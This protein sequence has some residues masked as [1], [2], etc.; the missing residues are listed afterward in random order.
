MVNRMGVCV[1]LLWWVYCSKNPPAAFQ[2]FM[3]VGPSAGVDA[4][5][6]AMVLVSVVGVWG[7]GGGNDDQRCSCS[8]IFALLLWR[9]SPVVRFAPVLVGATLRAWACHSS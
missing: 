4:E 7:V 8:I 5:E 2:R 1:L 3:R 6:S 9:A